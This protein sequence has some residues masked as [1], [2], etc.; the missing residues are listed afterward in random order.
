MG[1]FTRMNRVLKSNLNSLVDKA[2]DPEKLIAQTVTDMES[3]VKRAKKDLLS[4]LGTAKR[5]VK[6][7]KEHEDEA[8]DWERKAVLAL[9]EGDE[10]LA[11]EAL[12]RKARAKAQADDV[13]KQ[14]LDAESSADE[15][16]STLENVERKID[17]LKNKKGTLAAQVRRAREAPSEE[18]G[19]S[20]G[21]RFRSEALDELDRMTGRI[22]QLEAE[23]E[24][25]DVIDDPKRAEVDARFR[26]LERGA[27]DDQVED[28]LAALKAKLD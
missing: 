1:I 18:A 24:A 5:L 23:V 15:M 9:K 4:T 17:E 27:K 14:A 11:R 10:D 28:E 21:G 26:A 6:K 7:A 20:G 13:R 25:A 8:S 16:K 3:E 19:G 12:R 22:D 2:E